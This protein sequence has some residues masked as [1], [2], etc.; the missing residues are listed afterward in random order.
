MPRT[1]ISEFSAT[2]ADNTDIDGINLGEGMLPSD[3]NNSIRELMAQ[4]KDLQAGTSGDT[5]PITAGGTGATSASA[6]RTALGLAIGTNVQAFDSDTT[7]NDVANT[8]TVNQIVSVTDN[9]NA[10]LRITQLGTGNA[11]L[12]EDTTNPDSSPFV[13]NNDGVLVSGHTS[14]IAGTF[15]SAAR[16]EQIDNT[17]STNY[18]AARFTND[19]GSAALDLLKSRSA[20][21]GTQTVVQSGDA[22]GNIYFSGSDGTAFIRGALIRSEVDGTPGTNDMPGRLVFSTTADGSSTPVERMRI[23]NA[24]LVGV[25]IVPTVALDVVGIIKAQAASTQDAVRLQGRAGGTSSFA[26]TL[27]P[28]TLAANRTITLPN[29]DINFTTGLPIANGGTGATT[30]AAG[31]NALSPITT[32]G[33]LI[34]G[35]GSNSATRLAIGTSGQVLTSNGT[36]ASWG[37][38]SAAGASLSAQV[39]TSNGTFTIPTGVTKLK[40]TV[41]GGGGGGGGG[42]VGGGGGAGGAAISY[43]SSLTPGNTLSVTI[44]ASGTGGASG[45]AGTDGGTSSVASGTQ[46]ITTISTTGGGGGGAG[47]NPGGLGGTGTNGTLNLGGGDGAGGVLGCT[48]TPGGNGGSSL[49]GG[50]G[51]GNY[52]GGNPASPGRAYGGGGGGGNTSG[53]GFAGVVIFEW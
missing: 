9:S 43:L 41:V 19:T 18:S 17:G 6:A 10:A 8:F 14:A 47:Q 40:I 53:A 27:T 52:G 33:D 36:T 38:A 15:G 3:V 5:I 46:S 16:I 22:L 42:T 39:F 1:K 7:K 13:V 37:A 31:F 45:V 25:G 26:V 20:T 23:T 24:G 50:G 34:I 28:T 30:K 44:G 35:N 48:T 11:L 51:K 12:V 2:A 29:A 49:L 4:L 21:I 32:T